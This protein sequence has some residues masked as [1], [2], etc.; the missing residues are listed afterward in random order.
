MLDTELNKKTK[1]FTSYKDNNTDEN[2]S[3]E[4]EFNK[5]MIPEHDDIMKEFKLVRKIGLTN[6]HLYSL[7]GSIKKYN[8]IKDILREYYDER[9]S[10]YGKRK[11]YMLNI[12]KNE[13][14][15]MTW[16]CKFILMVVEKKL[17]VNNR[18][19]ADIEK[20]LENNGF[21]K[22]SDSGDKKSYNY[23]LSMPIYNLTYEKIE[24]LKKMID[25][26]QTEYDT[27]NGKTSVN[28]WREELNSL[29]DIISTI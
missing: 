7:N 3:F 16:K 12:M 24:E 27:L 11:E 26:K 19:R 1:R 8:S 13:L 5:G 21:P 25:N 23:L 6:M 28:I 14:D 10:M 4:I 22:M 18:K 20:S 2:I 9:L 15:L 29:K 17:K